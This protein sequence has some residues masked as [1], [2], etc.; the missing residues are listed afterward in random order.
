M[1]ISQFFAINSGLLI[2]AVVI[3]GLLIGSFLNVV[4]HRL[5]IMLQTSW[6]LECR[7]L[8]SE[9]QGIE[10]LN[11]EP[12]EPFNLV[13]PNSHCPHCQHAIRAWENIPIISYLFLQGKCSNCKASI[14][15]RYPIVEL[16]TGIVS[17]LIAWQFG[18]GLPM[19]A[20]LLLT[21]CLIAL[22][23]IDFDH[24]LLPDNIT[25]PLV[26]LGLIANSAGLF[27]NLPDAVWGAIAGYVSLWS[28]YWLFKLLTGKE[29]MGFGDFKLLAALGA[30]LGWQALPLIILLSSLVG[31]I[32]GISMIIF[33]GRDRQIPIPF[34][35][36]LAAAGW[37]SLDGS[38]DM[39]VICLTS[40]TTPS[41]IP[42]LISS[43]SLSLLNA[44]TFFTRRTGSS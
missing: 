13:A 12:S 4:I 21:W 16:L 1:S 33:L 11:C 43:L 8:L 22:T 41:T 31:A 5:P 42:P 39:A 10:D 28:V 2:L 7:L 40:Q 29:G 35:P 27:T 17:G 3:L 34:G 36:Y 37:I 24:Q 9:E 30:W 32:V 18:L 26:W 6:Q 20:A 25:L 38:L 19:L 44:R 23:M 15:I 14:S